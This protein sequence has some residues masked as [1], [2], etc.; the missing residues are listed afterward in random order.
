[1]IWKTSYLTARDSYAIFLLQQNTPHQNGEEI[2][3]ERPKEKDHATG[4]EQG[5]QF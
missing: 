4:S 5:R 3:A 1:M 2:L